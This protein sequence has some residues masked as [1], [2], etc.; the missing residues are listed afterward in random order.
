M[1]L[2][3]TT[4]SCWCG[5]L[6]VSV[7]MSE[8][9]RKTVLKLLVAVAETAK[10]CHPF[11][12]SANAVCRPVRRC[13]VLV[14]KLVSE[15]NHRTSQVDELRDV[16]VELINQSGRHEENVELQLTALNQRWHDVDARIRV[17]TPHFQIIN[18]IIILIAIII[19]VSIIVKICTC[20]FRE[21]NKQCS[22]V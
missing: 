13:R 12:T 1:V 8:V 7:Q 16:A 9:S 3:C 18:S 2:R 20:C 15:R 14:Q 11:E 17:C 5:N 22:T 6:S 4:S 21:K 10:L 19:I